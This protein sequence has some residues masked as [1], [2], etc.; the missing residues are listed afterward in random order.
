LLVVQLGA[1]INRR[2][3]AEGVGRAVEGKVHEAV[4]GQSRRRAAGGKA[5]REGPES[6]SHFDGQVIWMSG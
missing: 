6:D 5:E 3:G 4:S 1:K 2:K